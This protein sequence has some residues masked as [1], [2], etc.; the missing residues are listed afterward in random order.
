MSRPCTPCG[1][2]RGTFPN[3]AGPAR[4]PTC[5]PREQ[6]QRPS[7]TQ[8]GP[9]R[10][11]ARPQ[12]TRPARGGSK[13]VRGGRGRCA[14]RVPHDRT[15]G[16]RARPLAARHHPLAAAH[17]ARRCTTGRR[18]ASPDPGGGGLSSCRVQRDAQL[19]HSVFR[20][21]AATLA[22]VGGVWRENAYP[23]AACDVPSHISSSFAPAP[24]EHAVRPAAGHPA[25][26][27]PGRR[28]PRAARHLAPSCTPRTGITRPTC[29][30]GVR[31]TP[32]MPSP[33]RGDRH[34]LHNI[35]DST[36]R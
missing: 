32:A 15:P 8:I 11:S 6:V 9:T 28:R 20:G 30:I 22:D 2:D 4:P 5:H 24:V 18:Q 14:R 31:R 7:G 26:T 19:V 12:S 13:R 21:V 27:A 3:V 1:R 16:K 10:S 33:R 17:A 25:P 23:G 35:C 36:T 34:T 29:G